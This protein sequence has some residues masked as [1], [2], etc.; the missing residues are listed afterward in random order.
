MFFTLSEGMK[1]SIPAILK[2]EIEN[3]SYLRRLTKIFSQNVVMVGFSLARGSQGDGEASG[4]A[5][6]DFKR[7][8]GVGLGLR[9]NVAKV[10]ALTCGVLGL[11]AACLLRA[12][13][14]ASGTRR[15]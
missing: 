8:L 13:M 1:K 12:S 7:L 14:A 10:V 4:G 6:V 5:G 11:H 15:V 9:G 3:C 2:P